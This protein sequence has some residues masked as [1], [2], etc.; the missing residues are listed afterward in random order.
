MFTDNIG[1]MQDEA[2]AS[3]SERARVLAE[4]GSWGSGRTLDRG[5]GM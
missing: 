3:A 1:Y 5:I 4:L 2:S